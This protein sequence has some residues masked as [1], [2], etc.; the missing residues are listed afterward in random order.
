[1]KHLCPAVGGYIRRWPSISAWWFQHL[2]FVFTVP[3]T[4]AAGR[5]SGPSSARR[6][7]R[8]ESK[9]KSKRQLDL[10]RRP[11]PDGSCVHRLGD[12][13]KLS[14]PVGKIPVRGS[15]LRPIE[16]VERFGPELELIAFVNGNSFA[17]AQIGLPQ[18]GV[19][20]TSRGALPIVPEAGVAKAARLIQSEGV[21]PPGGVRETPGTM[22]GR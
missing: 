5:P 6:A 18:T 1:M 4:R 21:A 14:R 2:L 19:L 8:R 20:G 9:L 11:H 7:C 3:Y 17:Q 12:D 10:P 16:N 13:A 15:E 22:F